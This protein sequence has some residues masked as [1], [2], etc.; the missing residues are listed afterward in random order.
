MNQ[1]VRTVTAFQSLD[2]V[3]WPFA[4]GEV[5]AYDQGAGRMVGFDLAGA[6]A[7]K[8]STAN[9]N[10]AGG[11]PGLDGTGKILSTQLPAVAISDFLGSVA[12]EAAMLLLTG[13]RGDWA[14]RTDLSTTWILIDD[15]PTDIDS[16]QEL[17]SPV[18]GVST[19]NGRSGAVTLVS[20]D[21][22]G[23][24]GYTPVN[25]RIIDDGT[26]ITV[27]CPL[28]VLTAGDVS[29]G[30]DG[31]GYVLSIDD[32]S[33]TVVLGKHL[34]ASGDVKLYIQNN[35]GVY[36][37][38]DNKDV[39]LGDPLGLGN[40]KYLEVSAANSTVTATGMDFAGSRFMGLRSDT[41]PLLTGTVDPTTGWGVRASSDNLEGW[42]TG[43]KVFTINALGMTITGGYFVFGLTPNAKVFMEGVTAGV[44]TLYDDDLNGWD[45]LAFGGNTNAFPAIKRNA[46][47]LNFRL[48]DDSADAA[49]TAAGALFS[50]AVGIGNTAPAAML[51]VK[52]AQPASVA[53][54][55][56]TD[57]TNGLRVNTGAGEGT[58][59]NTTIATTG[60]G[61]AGANLNLAT[62]VGG[63]ATAAAT[64]ST[65]GAGGT[66]TIAGGAGGA[67][68]V[69]GT[70]TNTGG[71]GGAFSIT[72]GTGG[73][74]TGN[75]SGTNTGGTGGALTFSGGTGGAANTGSGT[76]AAGGGGSIIVQGGTGGVGSTTSG[77]GGAATL[78]GGAA[79][80][81][82][83]SA[84]GAANVAGRDGSSTGSGG[85]GGSVNITGG[86]AGG[87]GTVARNGGSINI[88]TGTGIGAGV[89][90]RVNFNTPVTADAVAE[91]MIT[92]SGS[93]RRALTLQGSRPAGN[94]DPLFAVTNSSD[95]VTWFELMTDGVMR[96]SY[97][98][99]YS[100]GLRVPQDNTIGFTASN[101]N[102][103]TLVGS[104]P[105]VWLANV[106]SGVTRG[107]SLSNDNGNYGPFTVGYGDSGT[108]TVG[109]GLTINRRSS[110][111]PAAGLGAGLL[112]QIESSTTNDCDAGLIAAAWYT[113]TH[114][115]RS[116]RIDFY[117]VNA[118]AALARIA[119]FLPDGRL[120]QTTPNSAPTDGD[121]ANGQVTAYLD[122][123][124]N[125]LKF[126]VKYSDGTLK[127][128]TVALV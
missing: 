5:A 18:G 102:N 98:Y 105:S 125:N 28:G 95:G 94:E 10:Q 106:G 62:G 15:D 57:A 9:K 101:R 33:R 16:W 48:A 23:A 86:N 87:D 107:M 68:A 36:L 40:G 84:G 24:L 117:T 21:V 49:I 104:S 124:G 97:F 93:T 41:G 12:S 82:A 73:A 71:T 43:S 127:T 128:G 78:R 61:G 123:A 111:T 35:A 92:A 59:G 2:D 79:A 55:T 46:A 67:A 44:L 14:I 7:A 22:T 74:A 26:D 31:Q 122:E 53:T 42:I 20:G 29:A 121:L 115:S 112:F 4:D 113:A 66:F 70:G 75:S 90:G 32:S 27:T 69:A 103:G 17:A 58:G 100:A 56:G 51:H 109:N 76:N 64:A 37:Q 13:E 60:T 89:K 126:R 47:A 118:A 119:S 25:A 63:Q 1:I 88:I 54:A 45:R 80:A 114:A 85:A 108:T 116:G 6:L 110:N 11:Y 52:S 96:S 99:L 83:G 65:G 91:V 3:G 72:G 30:I 19:F 50:G 39:R 81:A 120:L 34:G 38:A 8:E 77:A